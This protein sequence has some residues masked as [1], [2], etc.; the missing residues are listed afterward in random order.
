[1]KYIVSVQSWSMPTP[2]KYVTNLVK[3][4]GKLAVEVT[5]DIATARRFETRDLA[6]HARDEIENADVDRFAK[7]ENV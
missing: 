2:K 5:S 6:R 7:V 1:M 3:V 4:R